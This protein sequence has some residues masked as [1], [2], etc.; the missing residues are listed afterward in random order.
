MMW[1]W[2]VV[3]SA[4]ADNGMSDNGTLQPNLALPEQ[5]VGGLI[6]TRIVAWPIALKQREGWGLGGV[7]R[8]GCVLVP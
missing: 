8:A 5:P 6:A 7:L 4:P 2:V 3:K 1:W